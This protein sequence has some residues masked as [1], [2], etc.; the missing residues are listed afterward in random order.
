MVPSSFDEP[1]MHMQFPP[2]LTDE[3]I[4][5]LRQHLADRIVVVSYG[6]GVDSLALILALRAAGIV[7]RLLLFANFSNEKKVTYTHL[8]DVQGLLDQWG[9]PPITE[10][11]YRP[12]P[13][14]GYADLA[15]N[16][17][18][19]FTMPSLA[20]GF[21]GCS[22]KWK[23]HAMDT[24]LSG[25]SKGPNKRPPHPLFLACRASGTRL[26]RVIGYDASGADVD[27]AGR[28]QQVDDGRFEFCYPLQLIGWARR[29]CIDA[30]VRALGPDMVPVKSA[31]FFCPGSKQWEVCHLAAT[32]PD[33]LEIALFIEFNAMTGPHSRYDPAD[34][35]G[36]WLELI[37]S[38]KLIRSPKKAAVIGLG[39][40]WSWNQFCRLHGIVDAQGRV[41]RTPEDQARFLRLAEEMRDDDN[42]LDARC[43]L[44]TGRA[45]PNRVVPIVVQ[46]ALD[47][48]PS[49]PPL[50]RATARKAGKRRARR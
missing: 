30:I 43:S 15:G 1:I 16:C 8:E 6:V 24:F 2:L 4:A 31:C 26:M 40:D 19:N 44:L 25:I 34:F 7:P 3:Q 14:V 20:F 18:A 27:R 36:T 32:D 5:I 28:V 41:R 22:A 50:H 33:Q 13:A 21:K 12:G 46:Q 17:I 42:A 37:E 35:G 11:R 29:D 9:W 38:P 49:E 45:A 39:R 47:L 23:G 48:G 10:V